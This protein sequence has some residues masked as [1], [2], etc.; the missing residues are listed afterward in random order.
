MERR[1]G[2]IECRQLV[3]YIGSTV[4]KPRKMHFGIKLVFSISPFN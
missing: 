2:D 3:D 4:R 1:H